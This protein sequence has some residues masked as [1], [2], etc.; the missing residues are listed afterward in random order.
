MEKKANYVARVVGRLDNRYY[1]IEVHNRLY[2]I[3][4]FN[5]RDVRNYLW[6]FFPKHF[7]SYNVYDVTD[8][9]D[10]YKIKSNPKWLSVFKSINASSFISL[11]VT[12][13]LLFFP[14]TFAH[15][16][17]IPQL[18]LPILVVFVV[19]LLLIITFLNLGLDKSI[20]LGK[21]DRKIISPT[22]VIK[23]EKTYLPE[24]LAKFI[25]FVLGLS[26]CFLLGILTSNYFTLFFFTFVVGYAFILYPY[27][28]ETTLNKYKFQ[29]KNIQEHRRHKM[30]LPL[31]SIVYL[32]DGNQKI[33]II[34]RGMIVN[35]EGADVVFDYTGSVFPDGLNP[36]KI[37]YFN[38]E[39][40]DEV[41]F[42]G[43]R[44]DEEERYAKLYLQ[45]L[46]ENKE[47]VVK[48]KTK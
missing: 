13:W 34:G 6:G 48:G 42:E 4:Y 33:V 8:I 47:K 45:W 26:A 44:N 43:Y 1:L 22:T 28:I 32:A 39:D 40:I 36:E 30:L 27:F 21:L 23:S 25:S 5:P 38:E 31:G 29:I 18:W 19:G 12:L 15:N 2:V 9:S 7:S 11:V 46:E 41:I 17:K 37:Y 35:Q 3:D 20:D 16:D 10:R 14:P 24:K